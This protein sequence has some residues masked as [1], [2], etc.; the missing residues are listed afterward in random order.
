ME[1]MDKDFL[2]ATM[3]NSSSQIKHLTIDSS[4]SF[5]D[6]FCEDMLALG[7]LT[8]LT[9]LDASHKSNV[10]LLKAC[11]NLVQL[12]TSHCM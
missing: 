9:R 3:L 4:A 1:K 7:K 8:S 5:E 6:D 11:P 10:N 2:F 12:C